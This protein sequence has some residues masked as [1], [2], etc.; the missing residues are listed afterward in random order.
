MADKSSVL[1]LL[2]GYP[3]PYGG[4]TI[5]TRRLCK[6]LEERGVDYILYNAASDAEKGAEILSVYRKR[7]TWM[8]WYAL[9]GK[10]PVV[11]IMSP[12]LISWMLGAF[13]ASVR[14]KK[15]ILRI[16]N[17]RLID[18]CGKASLRR[19]LAAF[20]LRRINQIISVN[21]EIHDQLLKL[22]VHPERA[23]IIPGFLPPAPADLD[24]QTVTPDIWEFV[25]NH[26]PV[27]AANGKI[28]FYQGED[29]YGLDHLVELAIHLKTEYPN[30]GIIFCFSSFSPDDQN[31]L[32]ELLSKAEANGVLNN[33]FFNTKGGPFLPILNE[34]DL[35]VRPTNTDGDANSIREAMYMGVPT[36]ASDAVDRPMGVILFKTRDVHLFIDQVKL[37]LANKNI[38]DISGGIIDYETRNN[39]DKYLAL[40]TITDKKI[41]KFENEFIS[42]S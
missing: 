33:I 35:F 19:S 41:E 9:F 13:L 2:G 11:Y 31:Y 27:I 25:R 6:L 14:G 16:Q 1:A 3:P 8:L 22:G 32:N 17:S 4:V 30:F 7:H 37:A 18:W 39:I 26:D 36:I 29:L 34:A 42:G 20:S 10:E 21:R 40:I 15:V 23:H 28:T 5:H 12:R 38:K 24:S